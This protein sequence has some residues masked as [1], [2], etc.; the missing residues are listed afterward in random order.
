[1]GVEPVPG[2]VIV[3]PVAVQN[4]PESHP[5]RYIVTV[6]QDVEGL[7]VDYHRNLLALNGT[8]SGTLKFEDVFVPSEDVLSDTLRRSCTM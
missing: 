3:L 1:M 5:N 8:E 7:S 6:R 4:A 2:G